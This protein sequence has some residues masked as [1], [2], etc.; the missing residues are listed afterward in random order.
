[1]IPAIIAL[2]LSLNLMA[3]AAEWDMLSDAEQEDLIEVVETDVD[4]S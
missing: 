3:S 4:M 1:M 2:L